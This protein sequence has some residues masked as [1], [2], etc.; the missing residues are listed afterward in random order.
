MRLVK[1]YLPIL[2]DVVEHSR[3][4]NQPLLN[5]LLDKINISTAGYAYL[6]TTVRNFIITVTYENDCET[7]QL[8]EIFLASIESFFAT[9]EKFEIIAI[10]NEI[11]IRVIWSTTPSTMVPLT[12]NSEYEF[13]INKDDFN[14]KKCW[15]CIA[16]FISSLLLRNS[17]TQENIELILQSKQNGERLIDRVS[18]LQ[19]TK[20]DMRNVLGPTFKY[21]LEDWMR[22]TDKDYIYKGSHTDFKERSYINHLQSDVTTV[23]INSDM[24]LW[25]DAGWKGCGFVHDV[26]GTMPPFFGLAFENLE[27][28]QAI[29]SEWRPIKDKG[30]PNVRIYIIKGIDANNPAYYRICIAPV[31]S[32][33]D[34][35]EQRYI[36]TITRKHTMTPSSN[37]NLARFEEQY[38]RFGGCWL[39]AFQITEN[40]NII[41]PNSF[42]EAFKFNDVEFREAYLIDINDDAQI[43][44]EPDDNPYIPKEIDETAPIIRVLEGMREIIK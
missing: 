35:E 20:L 44:I 5:Q 30:K 29:T 1:K 24:T 19:H 28:G 34:N 6:K 40:N 12:K 16:M 13:R 15:E 33:E 38:K 2:Q 43:A 26:Y 41:M 18:V 14:D 22:K 17:V 11:N 27:R 7:Q 31:L 8:I 23:K 25:D 4:Q 36:A 32:H 39:M 10:D 9:F 3:L 37:E 42:D 21:K